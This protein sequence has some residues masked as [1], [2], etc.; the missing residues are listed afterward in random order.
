MSDTIRHNE[1]Q[2]VM[3]G[4]FDKNWASTNASTLQGAKIIA[5][6]MYEPTAGVKI[7]VGKVIDGV[8]I[9]L[10]ARFGLSHWVPV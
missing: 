3:R 9:T 10:A 4:R 8:Y 6:R 5:S 1:G 7:E 2:Y